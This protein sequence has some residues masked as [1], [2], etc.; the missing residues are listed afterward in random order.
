MTRKKIITITAFTYSAPVTN[1]T[2]KGVKLY[3]DNGTN[4]KYR[5]GCEP[6]GSKPSWMKVGAEVD[7]DSYVEKDN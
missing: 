7:L 1:Y 4:Y 5:F 3:F 2:C 6:Q